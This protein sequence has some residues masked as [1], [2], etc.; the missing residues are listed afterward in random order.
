MAQELTL[1][2]DLAEADVIDAEPDEATLAMAATLVA[3][4]VTDFDPADYYH[5]VLAAFEKA[6][7][8]APATAPTGRRSMAS[9]PTAKLPAP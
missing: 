6:V 2:A 3:A 7:G 5:D 9:A 8:E 4:N 1:P